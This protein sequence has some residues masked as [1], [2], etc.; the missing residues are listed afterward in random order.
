MINGIS[1]AQ[2]RI[3]RQSSS[4]TNPENNP[5][6]RVLNP[7]ISVIN[8]EWFV[9][10]WLAADFVASR[11]ARMI[12]VDLYDIAMTKLRPAFNSGTL[13]IQGVQ[14]R[15]F[16]AFDGVKYTNTK[17][18]PFLVPLKQKLGLAEIS[19]EKVTVRISVAT[20]NTQQVMVQYQENVAD[21]RSENGGFEFQQ[22]SEN[23]LKRIAIVD[24]RKYKNGSLLLTANLG[25]SSLDQFLTSELPATQ[26]GSVWNELPAFP[27]TNFARVFTLGET[28][29]SRGVV[30]NPV[31]TTL[32]YDN[33]DLQ[34]VLDVNSN[35]ARKNPREET[36]AFAAVDTP[37]D[38]G[39]ELVL[40][41]IPE[42]TIQIEFQHR[43]LGR[44]GKQR[45]GWC[46]NNNRYRVEKLDTSPSLKW[47]GEE[48]K[49]GN[50][51]ELRGFATIFNEGR[52]TRKF[53]G[54]QI[55]EL[56]GANASEGVVLTITEPSIVSE[57]VRTENG[58]IQNFACRIAG[59]V[60]LKSD[61]ISSIISLFRT[62][63]SFSA[64]SE[65]FLTSL[66]Q[67]PLRFNALLDLYVER[68]DLSDG[69]RH[70]FG[71]LSRLGII[72]DT[73]GDFVF[74]DQFSTI[75]LAGNIPPL[76]PGNKYMW[77]V[78]PILRNPATLLNK[79]EAA[80]SQDLLQRYQILFKKYFSPIVAKHGA[81]PST[82]RMNADATG[83]GSVGFLGPRDELMLGLLP[84]NKWVVGST[85]PISFEVAQQ[86]AERVYHDF[87]TYT[88]Y[89]IQLDGV[90]IVA[91]THDGKELFKYV[92]NGTTNLQ[93]E[94][95]DKFPQNLPVD[96]ILTN[97]DAQTQVRL[98]PPPNSQFPKWVFE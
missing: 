54:V 84:Y 71:A 40:G 43:C 66:A 51:Y 27:P 60:R 88:R 41:K 20:T 17:W 13:V 42:G 6:V 21:I 5:H 94:V 33:H 18:I 86:R 32:E 75:S 55:V 34:T 31:S 26:T 83:V 68:I 90:G 92:C 48:L 77:V 95:P 87:H 16:T 70:S 79:T 23:G 58:F 52:I 76:L 47:R 15:N 72:P 37:D 1:G 91:A 22:I 97:G 4:Q 46:G 44:T 59:N 93:F 10:V 82:A 80:V 57:S 61:L 7:S 89:T 73:N 63:P 39:L 65:A 36:F 85:P 12:Y 19:V 64:Q 49:P 96:L 78:R 35:Q 81:L 28:N 25:G 45:Q 8:G 98:L 38:V 2:V 56:G 69:T 62:Q 53:T 3:A 29:P 24:N 74:A 50:L 30:R 11:T 67:D 14:E 9:N